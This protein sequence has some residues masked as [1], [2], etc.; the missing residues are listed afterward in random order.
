[1]YLIFMD[2]TR[3]RIPLIEQAMTAA[4]EGICQAQDKYV[5]I[6]ELLIIKA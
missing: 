1:M 2:G 6:E 3:F 5:Y 4:D